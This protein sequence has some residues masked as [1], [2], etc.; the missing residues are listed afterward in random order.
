[1]LPPATDLEAM[2]DLEKISQ[3]KGFHLRKETDNSNIPNKSL[4]VRA[5]SDKKDCISSN[6]PQHPNSL[7][8]LDRGTTLIDMYDAMKILQQLNQI[9]SIPF[10]TRPS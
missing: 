3:P 8:S 1:M 10:K 5:F 2:H 7:N 6:I 4:N 9:P